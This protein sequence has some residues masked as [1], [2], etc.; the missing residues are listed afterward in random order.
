MKFPKNFLW[1]GA[2]AANQIEGAYLEDGK[3]LSTADMMTLGSRKQKRVI[4]ETIDEDKYYYPTHNAIDF[5]HH[6]EE[7]IRLFAEMGFNVYRMSIAWSRIFPNGDDAEPNQKGLAFYDKVIDLCLSYGIK[8]LITLSHFE[9]PMGLKKYGFWTSKKTIDF[10]VKYATTV[11]EH[12]KG[13]V[14]Y[15][16]TFN[17]INVMSTMPWN[18]GG[19]SLD[20]DQKTKDI[21]AYNQLIAS[22][23]VVKIAHEIDAN[24]KIGAMYCGHF[25]YANS[26]SPD[27]V[28]GN[29][30]FQ[31]KMIY[32][33][34]VQSRGYYPNYKLKELERLNIN[35]P[36]QTGDD[37]IL[38]D[39]TVD[40][41]SFSYYM[42]HVCGSKTK[43]IFKG[44]NGLETG[45]ENPYLEKS[46]WGWEIDPKGL[47]I[48]LNFLY[49]RYQKPVMVVENGL[50]AEDNLIKKQGHYTVEDDYRIDYLRKHLLEIEKAIN[51][52]GAPVMGYTAWGP[53]DLVAA[54]TG[55]MTKRYGF[56]YVDMDNFGR[57]T[58]N[59]YKKKSFNWYKNVIL[60]NGANL[61]E[62]EVR[63]VLSLKRQNELQGAYVK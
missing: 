38:R 51:I 35:L 52:D 25:S 21:A 37:E 13:R 18:A 6:Y 3:G 9:T 5:Y 24:N 15:W 20:A 1:G 62:D 45:Y 32:Y 12:F 39:G 57:G 33:I 26:A 50:G 8:P 43:G 40:F 28:Q 54:S 47:R 16:L 29:N 53:I 17:E 60:S 42:T 2:T 36:K 58:G 31:D 46:D 10:F 48:A 19:I 34:D 44:L 61:E 23:K 4:S 27:D 55:Q 30:N 41:I 56:I 59:R 49:D 14:N 63:N 7:D 22:A 11:L